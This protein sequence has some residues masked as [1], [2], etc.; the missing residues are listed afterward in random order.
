MSESTRFVGLDVHK[1]TIAVATAEPDGSVTEHGTVP[2]D[3]GAIRKLV[4]RLATPGVALKVAYEAGPTGY[5]LHRQLTGL[6]VECVVVAPSLIPQRPGDR[7]KTDQRDAVKLARLLRSGDLTPV[8]IPDEAHEALRNLVRSRGDAKA[9]ALRAKHRLSKFL[10]RQGT[11]PPVGVKA[12][13]LKYQTWLNSVIFMHPADQVVFEDYRAVQRAADERVRRLETALMQSADTSPHVRMI[14]ALQAF[15][16]I[17]FLTAITIVAEAGDLR[18]FATARQFMS[19]VGVV[20]SEYS[21]GASQHRGRITKT[22][23]AHLR[24]VFGE[25]AHHARYAPA[26]KGAVKQR[27]EGVPADVVDL[28]WRAQ[29]RLHLRYRHLSGRVG[30]PKA[31][32]AVAREFAGFVWALGQIMEVPAA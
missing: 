25:A 8:W 23:N 4:L 10:L 27:Q 7:V 1:E 13:S 12:W 17:A 21:S 32:T 14:A 9:D 24:H 6:G 28:S 19:Y 30:R 18:R 16:G 22:G 5:A 11:R 31:I 26:V 3:P 20:P 2:N 29:Q 15:R